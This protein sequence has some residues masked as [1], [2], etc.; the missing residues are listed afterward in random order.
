M[1]KKSV[2]V[3]IVVVA[4]ASTLNL[5]TVFPAGIDRAEAEIESGASSSVVLVPSDED[6][7]G[8]WGAFTGGSSRVR[9]MFDGVT[10]TGDWKFDAAL[11][12]DT[13]K[14]IESI[15][16][17]HS[18]PTERDIDREGWTTSSK[19]LV[20]GKTAYPLVVDYGGKQLNFANDDPLGSYPAGTHQFS[21]YAQKENSIFY[22][23][24]LRIKFTDGSSVSASIPA[25]SI[26]QAKEPFTELPSPRESSDARLSAQ[27][28][29]DQE[30]RV[31]GFYT[32]GPGSGGSAGE[33]DFKFEAILDIVLVKTLKSIALIH[34]IPGQIW[35]TDQG[36]LYPI[37]VFYGG[38]QLNDSFNSPLGEYQPGRHVFELY[39]QKESRN[40]EGGIL[41]FTFG[42]G[43]SA[44]CTL[45]KE[46]R[47]AKALSES[48]QEDAY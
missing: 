16:I 45:P 23:G 48:Y 27:Y 25:Q 35:T 4:A 14:T 15:S 19:V 11:S 6:R 2:R 12:L 28:Q 18:L 47:T 26:V 22:G 39:V 30:N 44:S 31:G 9:E 38:R 20:Y 32:F 3:G 46:E 34:S 21:L 33:Q 43:T 36:N 24:T 29:H 17:A 7:A 10:D 41:T 8:P 13:N 42:D 37:A 1:E 5:L 40:F